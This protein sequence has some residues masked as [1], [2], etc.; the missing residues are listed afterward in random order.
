MLPQAVFEGYVRFNCLKF[1]LTWDYENHKYVD[2][3]TNNAFEN[4]L[5]CCVFPVADEEVSYEDDPV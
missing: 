2:E 5:E 4:F 3:N 1:D